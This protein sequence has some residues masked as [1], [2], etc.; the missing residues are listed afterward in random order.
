MKKILT[1]MLLSGAL[2]FSA[3]AQKLDASKVP[4]HVKEAFAKKYPGITP[5]WEMEKGDFEAGF[6][7]EGHTMSALFDSNG[8]MKESEVDIKVMEL[9]STVLAYVKEHYK[10]AT[11]KEAAKITKADGTVNYEAEVN[12]MDVLFDINGKF[13]KEVKD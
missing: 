9:P 13:I 1:G 4:V 2:S 7:Q 11:I 10:G 3:F 12:K 8:I 5:K 6:K